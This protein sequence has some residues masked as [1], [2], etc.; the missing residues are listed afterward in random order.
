MTWRDV[1]SSE[2]IMEEFYK[3]TSQ[4]DLA[5]ILER[6]LPDNRD[7]VQAFL[8]QFIKGYFGSPDCVAILQSLIAYTRPYP[9]LDDVLQK[10]KWLKYKK[11]L[12]KNLYS[13]CKEEEMSGFSD[14]VHE[15]T[16]QVE[17]Y[18]KTELYPDNLSKLMYLMD[19]VLHLP[20]YFNAFKTYCKDK[21]E[22]HK[23]I[24][25]D[26]SLTDD[27]VGYVS[28]LCN[29][30]FTFHCFYNLHISFTLNIFTLLILVFFLCTLK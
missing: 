26:L 7:Q 14:Y 12:G 4:E 18:P 16:P 30:S 17:P 29:M 19:L 25:D 24:E 15:T 5:Q 2:E 11:N 10:L 6:Q 13:L 8:D 20:T 28:I 21:P 3:N 27:I 1:E 22:L 9:C 23:Y